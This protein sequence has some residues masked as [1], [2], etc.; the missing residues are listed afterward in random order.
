MSSG[1]CRFRLSSR[2]RGFPT[3]VHRCWKRVAAIAACRWTC[4]PGSGRCAP[5]GYSTGVMRPRPSHIWGAAD[6]HAPGQSAGRLVHRH[7]L[8]VRRVASILDS[9]TAVKFELDDE[10]FAR[11]SSF[12]EPAEE[13]T[14]QQTGRW[15]A[16][17]RKVLT[18]RA[19]RQ[20]RRRGGWMYGRPRCC[21]GKTDP[22]RR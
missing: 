19:P 1:G 13:G 16:G 14:S 10:D 8:V 22:K 4:P 6:T 20:R 7:R 21:K 12:A 11:V 2:R 3:R 18:T 5:S 17:W 9:L 15:S